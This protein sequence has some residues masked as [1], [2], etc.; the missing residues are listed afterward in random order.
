MNQPGLISVAQLTRYVK[1]LLEEQR[2]LKDL[3]VRGE[4]CDLYYRSASGHLYF[5]LREGESQLRCVMFS[6]YASQLKKWPEEGSAAVVR[7]T[8]SLYERDGSFQLIA[9]DIQTLGKGMHKETLEELK[10]RLYQEG[11]FDPGRKKPLPSMPRTVGVITSPEGAALQDIISTFHR[12]NPM[13]RLIV[14]PAAV[15]GDKAASSVM[16][17]LDR[18]D[19]EGLCQSCVIARGGGSSDDLSAF[20]DEALARR[21][22]VCRIPLVSAVGHEVDYTILDFVADA[23]AATPTAACQLM[24]GSVSLLRE[25][26]LR[27]QRRLEDSYRGKLESIRRRTERLSLLLSQNS[28]RNELKKNRQTLEYLIKSMQDI[29]QR[30]LERLRNQTLSTL[31]RLELVNPAALLLR[32]Y[33]I[34]WQGDRVLRHAADAL[35]GQT[36]RTRL[37]DGEVFSS[38]TEVRLLTKRDD[39]GPQQ[40]QNG[41]TV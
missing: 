9:Y 11:L 2:Q 40:D 29:Q 6:R 32:G 4:I 12:L 20:N 14:Y 27:R 31:A 26:V 8:V 38:V 16:A 3:L 36:L 21:A 24:T 18:M 37:E 33:S 7:G 34:T 25:E 13:V 10:K 41:T 1:S 15:Q 28:P 23:R 39:C 35:P 19:G 5:S 17:A 22:A 30:R